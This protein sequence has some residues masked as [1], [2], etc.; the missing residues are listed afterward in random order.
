MEAIQNLLT[1]K[2]R[3]KI[4]NRL[5]YLALMIELVLMIVEKSELTF[6]YESYVFRITFVIVF[7]AVLITDHENKEWALIAAAWVFTFASY[8]LTG[9]NELLRYVTFIMAAK[10]I[11]LGKTMRVMFWTSLVGFS[12]IALLSV[13]GI[14]GQVSAV[15]DFGRENTQGQFYL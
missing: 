9:K 3:R 1:Q 5:F 7:L 15:A 4:A 2:N 13:T 10:N 12:A 6:S 11:N 8:R 14:F